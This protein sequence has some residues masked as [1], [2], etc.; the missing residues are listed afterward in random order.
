RQ[1]QSGAALYSVAAAVSLKSFTLITPWSLGFSRATER[2]ASVSSSP[3]RWPFASG[4]SSVPLEEYKSAPVNDLHPRSW[5]WIPSAP[6]HPHKRLRAASER[7]ASGCNPCIW[8]HQL[9]RE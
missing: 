5:L 8:E 1:G 7:S 3:S 6:I 9:A 2:T 4:T